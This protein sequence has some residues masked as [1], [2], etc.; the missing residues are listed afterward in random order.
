MRQ[1]LWIMIIACISLGSLSACNE[2]YENDDT[3]ESIEDG[4]LIDTGSKAIGTPVVEEPVV[5]EPVVEEPVVE[6]PVVEEPVAEEPRDPISV[7]PYDAISG[8]EYTIE[9]DYWDIPNDG[10]DPV[11]TTDN[12]QAAIDWASGE[13]YGIIRLPAGHYLIGQYGTYNYQAG[14]ELKSNMAFLMD[15]DAIIEMAPNN[16]WNYCTVAV[17]RKVNVVISG[18]TILGDRYKHIYTP[19]E[20]DGATAHDEGHLICIQN[21]SEYVTVENVELGKANGDAI[22]LVG[23]GG[24]GSSVK[25]VD[26][27]ENNMFYNRRQGVSIV[28]GENILIE[29]NEIHHTGGTRPDFGIDIESLI[30]SSK[31]IIIRGNYFHHNRGGDIVNT[32]GRNVLVEDNILEQGEGS[33]YIDG[34]LVYWKN[35]DLTIRNNDITMLSNSV[36]GKF[37]IIMYSNDKPKTNPATTTIEGNTFNDCG[38]YIYK[39]AD[40]N[41]RDNNIINGNLYLTEMTNVTFSENYINGRIDGGLTFKD[42]TNLTIENNNVENGFRSSCWAYRLLQVTGSASG[43]TH[44]SEPID[45]LLSSELWDSCWYN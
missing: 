36:N 20:S 17:S 13:G 2:N 45:L 31:D 1:R 30:Y 19:R 18:G 16:K 40:L 5:E 11:K 28:G 29:D 4:Q 34:P 27:R 12:L 42:M 44:N 25:H 38:F 33:E 3:V 15:K 22:L 8:S 32:D 26:I 43:N 14:I 35:A 23:Q 24:E 41:I 7:M 6:E 10:T 21:E 9:L 39:G 37:G